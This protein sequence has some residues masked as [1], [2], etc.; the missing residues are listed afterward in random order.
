MMPDQEILG[1]DG[2]ELS[3]EQVLES[4]VES[5]INQRKLEQAPTKVQVR[6]FGRCD[7]FLQQSEYAE[8]II[9]SEGAAPRD[10]RRLY[11]RTSDVETFPL[12]CL[13][14]K[15][16]VIDN[17]NDANQHHDPCFY[18]SHDE[19]RIDNKTKLVARR[20]SASAALIRCSICRTETDERETGLTQFLDELSAGGRS[21]RSKLR[22]L[23][24]FAGAGG[25]STGERR[26]CQISPGCLIFYLIHF[27][28]AW[29]R[30]ASLKS[31]RPSKYAPVARRHSSTSKSGDADFSC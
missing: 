6:L 11:T 30:A 19:H 20:P 13:D 22:S 15:V 28:Q 9:S 3:P 5:A 21:P 16:T 7:D 14:G 25:L 1:E 8:P 12:K 10:E 27:L 18:V 26:V 2:E 31:P 24:L 17:V 4:I 23:D 29:S